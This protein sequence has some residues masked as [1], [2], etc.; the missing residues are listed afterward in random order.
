V[1]RVSSPSSS[2]LARLACPVSASALPST[3]REQ[4]R[5]YEDTAVVAERRAQ[6]AAS[7]SRGCW[8]R[9]PTARRQ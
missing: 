2:V 7:V 3:A 9:P 5:V 4:P 1:H 6:E 8:N